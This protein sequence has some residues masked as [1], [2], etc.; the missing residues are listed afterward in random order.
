MIIDISQ[1]KKKLIVASGVWVIVTAVYSNT[2]SRSVGFIDSGELATVGVTLGIAHPTGYPLFTLLARLFSMI[3]AADE[4]IVRMNILSMLCTSLAAVFFFFF[5][6]ELQS[7]S[8]KKDLD[9]SIILSAIAALLLAFSSTFWS[10]SVSVE[11]Y[12]L[13]LVLTTLIVLF[14]VKAVNTGEPRWWYVFAFVTGLAFTNHLTTVLLAPALVYWF[15]AEHG[16]NKIALRMIFR[17][18]IPFAAGF[19]VNAYLPVRASQHPLLNWGNPQTVENIWWHFSGKQFR[20]WMFSSSDVAKQQLEYFFSNLQNEFH[21]ITLIIAVIGAVSLL[22]SNRRVFIFVMVLFVSCVGYSINYDIHDINSYFLLA[23]IAV[24]VFVVFGMEWIVRQFKNRTGKTVV[25][26]VFCLV[27]ILQVIENYRKTDQS[28]N[29]LVED[30]TF[31]ILKNLPAHAVVLSTQWDYFVSASYY[32]QHVKNFRPDV[33]VLDKELFRRSWYFEQCERM[34]PELMQRSK[35]EIVSFIR[36]LYKFEHGIPYEYAAIEG[37][38]AALLKSFIEKNESVAFFITPEIE[39]QYT[40]GYLRIPEGYLF[41][42]VKDTAYLPAA[43]PEIRYREFSG[44]S[45]YIRSLKMLMV[46]ALNR[47]GAYEQYYNNDTIAVQYF[48]K[49]SEIHLRPGY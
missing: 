31:T 2:I 20:V 34:Y 37:R 24:V 40:Q 3:P 36:E 29:Y 14:F 10:Q 27:A 7:K 44:E 26:G 43:F 19:S 25:T 9:G 17:M 16:L 30:Y 22:F 6:L 47:R 12:S 35:E 41:R 39:L 8:E 33:I 49:A 13:H 23:F 48:Q 42:L 32:L 15:F 46:N 4:I 45:D 11:V 1:K 21:V 5:V 38:Y 18:A 28:S